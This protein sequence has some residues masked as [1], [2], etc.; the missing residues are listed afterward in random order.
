[1]KH[2]KLNL[3]DRYCI[4]ALLSRGC[5]LREIARTLGRSVST[6]SDEISR[7]R[8]S[9]S[10][11]SG[12]PGEY[13]PEVA[14]HKAYVKRKYAK[15]QGMKIMGNSDLKMFI[16]NA[17][18][19]LQSPEA[20]AGRL[21]LGRD[22][23]SHGDILP[24]VS[25]SCI[26]K[27]IHSVYGEAIRI[28]IDAMKILYKRR[29]RRRTPAK[30]DGRK[31]IDERPSVITN[32]KRL[33]DLEVDFIVSGRSGSGS[34]LTATDRRG[35]FSFIRKLY[36]VTIENLK[37]ALLDI[38]TRYPDLKSITTD[39]DILFV[40]HEQLEEILGIP[41]YFCH[42]YSSWEKGSVENLNKY[43]RKFI[44]KGSNISSYSRALIAT[45]EQKANSR[46]MG[47]IGY[48]TPA[49]FLMQE[50]AGMVTT[51]G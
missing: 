40:C 51:L 44:R 16:D 26:E 11:K 4:K 43:I 6:I 34:L 49:E 23:D 1:M 50:R 19:E 38:K 12:S 24:K 10:S 9:D 13:I 42:P 5:S 8:R 25:R 15:Y 41:I 32:R 21:A 30:L 29:T 36:P 18:L 3:E 2:R 47:V 35:R 46:F 14:H 37:I 45:I 27:Y 7:G 17:L 48:L 33:G 22:L 28:E 31:F 39:N 20:I